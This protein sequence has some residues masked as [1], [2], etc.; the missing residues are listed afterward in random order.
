MLSRKGWRIVVDSGVRRQF[1]TERLRLYNLQTP[2]KRGVTRNRSEVEMPD[3]GDNKRQLQD[4]ILALREK[5]SELEAL[6]NQRPASDER[7]SLSEVARE[8]ER[9]IDIIES[10]TDLVGTSTPDGRITFLNR[11][12]KRLVGLAEDADVS[13]LTIWQAPACE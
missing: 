6:L 12:G 2:S 9:L 4:E 5:V 1:D 7:R 11:A 3:G 13:R 10:T 8:R